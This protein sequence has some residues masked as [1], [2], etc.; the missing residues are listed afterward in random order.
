[1]RR[2]TL[3]MGFENPGLLFWSMEY[4]QKGY[5][6][7][8]DVVGAERW[9]L[10]VPC[11]WPDAFAISVLLRPKRM[12]ELSW[13][14]VGN[15]GASHVPFPLHSIFAFQT[16]VPAQD[17][18]PAQACGLRWTRPPAAPPS[19]AAARSGRWRWPRAQLGGRARSARAWEACSC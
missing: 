18:P 3:M 9:L 15:L 4:K 1:M 14:L 11:T 5:P 12:V 2:A 8:R 16:C 17:A 10:R 13:G 7:R 19:P 6:Q